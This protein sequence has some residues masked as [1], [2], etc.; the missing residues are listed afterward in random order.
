[1]G[2]AIGINEAKDIIKSLMENGK[3]S[4]PSLGIYGQ[5]VVSEEKNI[6]GVYVAQVVE[7]SGADAAG[8]K[9]ADI[10][11]ELDKKKVTKSDDLS[12]ILDK[13]KIGDSIQCKIL[14][15]G[16]AIEVNITL[17]EVKEKNR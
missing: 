6:A 3:V 1:M 13:H 12:E 7:G 9:R 2:F 17:S 15:N 4:R 11:I 8:I 16:K 10:I 5:E 14:R